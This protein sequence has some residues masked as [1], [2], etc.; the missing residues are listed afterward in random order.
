MDNQNIHRQ[1]QRQI[2]KFL[3]PE[4]IAENEAIRKFIDV[5]N[6]S[7]LSYERDAELFEQSSRLNDIEYTQINQRLK[8]EIAK[9]EE[10]HSKLIYAINQLNDKIKIE[11]KCT[12][13]PKTKENSLI[14]TNT[15]TSYSIQSLTIKYFIYCS[16][17]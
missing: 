6:L 12:C 8:A 11:D 15:F 2:N 1:L 16:R 3:S 5:V 13:L 14:T 7:Y 17:I 9:K 4:L 10:V